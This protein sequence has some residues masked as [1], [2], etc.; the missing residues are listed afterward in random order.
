MR[1]P[2]D[3]VA[4]YVI[5]SYR[6]RLLGVGQAARGWLL[7]EENASGASKAG[8]P[9]IRSMLMGW[10]GLAWASRGRRLD[11]TIGQTQ[12]G[13][14]A[15]P[16]LRSWSE[17]W[18]CPLCHDCKARERMHGPLALLPSV[19]PSCAGLFY[20]LLARSL[21]SNKHAVSW[22]R[23]GRRKGATGTCHARPDAFLLH[24]ARMGR[25]RM[26]AS[27]RCYYS[28]GKGRLRGG[29]GLGTPRPH[30]C[31]AALLR[32]CCALLLLLHPFAAVFLKAASLAL[33]CFV[34]A[35][36]LSCVGCMTAWSRELRALC[37]AIS[38]L[39][40]T[41]GV[42]KQAVRRRRLRFAARHTTGPCGRASEAASE[43]ASQN[44]GPGR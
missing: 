40:T 35:L 37:T 17:P 12:T 28:A 32:T 8:S 34:S 4:C 42:A 18:A 38:V 23:E 13:D 24:Q 26:T 15:P 3:G 5:I 19:R 44:T 41:V 29:G 43:R 2:T 20:R 36:R 16:A 22:R 39:S 27:A 10:R 6:R 7:S 31:V 14:G 1:H 21:A 25:L 9:S 30:R 11:W 33:L